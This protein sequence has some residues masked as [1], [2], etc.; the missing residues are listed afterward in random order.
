[1]TLRRMCVRERQRRRIFPRPV[2]IMSATTE[3]PPVDRPVDRVSFS[4]INNN[5]LGTVRVLNTTL[6]PVRYS[7][8]FY[9]DIVR[10]EVEEFCK[11]GRY[12]WISFLLPFTP[13]PYADAEFNTVY[14]NDVPVGTV[15]CRLEELD[16]DTRL[17]LMT[18]GVLAV[19]S[20]PPLFF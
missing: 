20:F 4:S 6:F 10:P 7:E 19:G 17:Y 2:C 13:V 9:K 11:L 8:K 16:N 15:C 14:I 12:A 5:N 18:M 3:Q 1:M